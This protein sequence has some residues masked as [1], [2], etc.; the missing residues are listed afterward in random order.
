MYLFWSRFGT[1]K[2]AKSYPGP[3]VIK[4]LSCSTQLNI[5]FIM[6]INVKMPTNIGILIFVSMINKTSESLNARKVF[7]FQYFSYYGQN[8]EQDRVTL[9]NS[10]EGR[11]YQRKVW[12]SMSNLP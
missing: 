10:S 9:S 6:L 7:I 2:S 1:G 11:L 12:F 3:E 8:L 5:K 4:L